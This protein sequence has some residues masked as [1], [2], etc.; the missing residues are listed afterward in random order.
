MFSINFPSASTG[1]IVC[2]VSYSHKSI[3][4]SSRFCCCYII[5]LVILNTHVPRVVTLFLIRERL[6]TIWFRQKQILS[7]FT[8][9]YSSSSPVNLTKVDKIISIIFMSSNPLDCS[10]INQ[11]KLILRF[12]ISNYLYF[13]LSDWTITFISFI[14]EIIISALRFYPI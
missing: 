13:S 10:S 12:A 3:L 4:Q 1:D 14:R 9:T 2:S 11:R 6:V 8:L 7:C 5:K